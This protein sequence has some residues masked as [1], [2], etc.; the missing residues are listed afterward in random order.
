[1]PSRDWRL[2][3][4]DILKAI[5]GIQQR[6]ATLTLE[7][8]ESNDTIAKT[9]LFDFIVLVRQAEIFRLPL[10]LATLMPL[11]FDERYAKHSRSRIF[12][13][14]FDP[15]LANDSQ[16][17]AS[18]DCPITTALGSRVGRTLGDCRSFSSL[19]LTVQRL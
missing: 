6:T 2:R 12:S 4:Q 14:Q 18:A 13:S 5:E 15:R 7:E 3:V 9:V 10:R 1:M 19:L 17:S 11:A 16:Q 8:F